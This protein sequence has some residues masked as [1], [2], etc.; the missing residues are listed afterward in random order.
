MTLVCLKQFIKTNE[1]DVSFHCIFTGFFLS[2]Y[3]TYQS[4]TQSLL[5]ER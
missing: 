2:F 5:F 3:L 1:F 4:N